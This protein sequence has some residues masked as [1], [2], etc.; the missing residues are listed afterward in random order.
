M[1]YNLLELVT[2]VSNEHPFAALS[3]LQVCGVKRF[4]H[5][6]SVV[7][8]RSLATFCEQRDATITTTFGAIQGIPVDPEHSTHDFPVVAGGAGLPSLLRTASVSYLGAFFRVARPL[9][10]RLAHMGCITTAGAAAFLKNHV[11]ANG[12][13]AWATSVYHTLSIMQP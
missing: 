3:L 8:P 9:I 6:L 2:Y 10:D 1:T 12:D 13:H 11:A 7:P 4:G 5:I